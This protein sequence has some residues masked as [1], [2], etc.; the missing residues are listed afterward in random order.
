[1]GAQLYPFMIVMAAAAAALAASRPLTHCSRSRCHPPPA[2]DAAH[3][4]SPPHQK[5]V[6]HP[7]IL[8]RARR[9]PV[10]P[11]FCSG[12]YARRVTSSLERQVKNETELS[13]G[14]KIEADPFQF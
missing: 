7:P 12:R 14:F 2:G 4:L 1:M 5:Q 11:T 6:V 3:S 9:A 8:T 13:N 10:T